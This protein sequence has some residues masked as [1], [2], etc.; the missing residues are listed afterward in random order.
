MTAPTRFEPRTDLLASDPFSDLFRRFMRMSDWPSM[1][2][3]E[4]LRM[5]EDMKL[6]VTE[7]DKEYIVKAELPGAKKE[8]IR[9]SVDG[10]YVS[11]SAETKE[12]KKETKKHN[13]ERTLLHEMHYGS[14]SRGFTLPHEVDDKTA[15]A[16]FE[17]GVLSLT[18]PK[19]APATS[20]SIAIK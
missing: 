17:N 8:D 7:N 13:G 10:S 4:A 16:K 15:D 5:P 6:D 14:W 3:P 20:K 2:M 12:E 18:L 11:I 9:I 19:R 1:R